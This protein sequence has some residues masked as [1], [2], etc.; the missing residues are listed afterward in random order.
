MVSDNKWDHNLI[1][2][3][4]FMAVQILDDVSFF[5]CKKA[6]TLDYSWIMTYGTELPVQNGKSFCFSSLLATLYSA[7]EPFF[8]TAGTHRSQQPK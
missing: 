8:I 5:P 6:L 2:H 4:I 3:L 1:Y 7:C